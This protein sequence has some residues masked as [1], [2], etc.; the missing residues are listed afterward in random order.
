M[1]HR[2]VT[3]N[4][5]NVLACLHVPYSA[6]NQRISFIRGSADVIEIDF[7]LVQVDVVH[8]YFNPVPEKEFPS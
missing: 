5:L 4:D 3:I 2:V 8:L 6:R 1:T 7:S